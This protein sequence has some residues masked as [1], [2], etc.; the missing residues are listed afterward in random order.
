MLRRVSLTIPHILGA[1]YDSHAEY[2]DTK[3]GRRGAM[4]HGPGAEE[5]VRELVEFT[6]GFRKSVALWMADKHPGVIVPVGERPCEDVYPPL[7]G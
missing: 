6:R 3:G 1:E 5:E 7:E 2:L 4:G